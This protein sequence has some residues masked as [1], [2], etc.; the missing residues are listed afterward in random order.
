MVRNQELLNTLIAG[1]TEVK[2]SLD[3]LVRRM[4]ESHVRI[5]GGEGVKGA[6]VYLHEE[7]EALEKKIERVQEVEIKPLA[8]RVTDL[9]TRATIG[10]WKLGAVSAGI[11]AVSG[12]VLSFGIM[13]FKAK[14]GIHS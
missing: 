14:L 9:Q 6:L 13:W 11:G 10:A 7:N 4:D 1:Q 8:D 5:F 3:N 12:S 2:V